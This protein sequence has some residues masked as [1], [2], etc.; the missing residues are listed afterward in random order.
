MQLLPWSCSRNA[1]GVEVSG[2]AQLGPAFTTQK[3]Y[4]K[5]IHHQDDKN[6]S[7]R[8]YYNNVCS[9]NTLH[10]EKILFLYR[11]LHHAILYCLGSSTAWCCKNTFFTDA[12]ITRSLKTTQ[13]HLPCRFGACFLLWVKSRLAPGSGSNTGPQN[14]QLPGIGP[15]ASRVRDFSI[16]LNC[17]QF[18]VQSIKELQKT[19]PHS[20]QNNL[21]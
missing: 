4:S 10:P 21:A 20:I 18:E 12:H 17:R 3:Q 8:W 11:L 13:N 14:D 15:S 2:S 9:F 5:Q 19:R 7:S 16:M 1:A 6:S